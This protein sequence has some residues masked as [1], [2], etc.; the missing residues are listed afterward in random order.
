[1]IVDKRAPQMSK[2][3]RPFVENDSVLCVDPHEVTWE[4]TW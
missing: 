4:N 1:M 2:P 3:V